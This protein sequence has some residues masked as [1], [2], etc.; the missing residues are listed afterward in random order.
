VLGAVLV[1]PHRDPAWT[2][3]STLTAQQL[4]TGALGPGRLAGVV[5]AVGHVVAPA[6]RRLGVE[7]GGHGLGRAG[8]L[9]RG[10]QRLARTEQGLRGNAGPVG[11]LAAQQLA[12]HNRH[13][14]AGLG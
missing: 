3:E 4:D 11:A 1:V 7:A 2:D 13:A 8:R 12:L 5:V 10:R 9:A 14:L 6:E